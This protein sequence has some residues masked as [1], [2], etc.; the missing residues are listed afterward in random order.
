[1]REY[2]RYEEREW[3]PIKGFSPWQDRAALGWL[4]AGLGA[5]VGVA[6]L[7]SPVGRNLRGNI[8]SGCR[9]ALNG[10]GNGISRGTQELREHGSD[11]LD[12]GRANI[13]R[14]RS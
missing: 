1:M 5:G 14:A 7:F 8:A 11:L 2:S 12:S 9:R 4:L 13:R 6:L 3:Q 10:L